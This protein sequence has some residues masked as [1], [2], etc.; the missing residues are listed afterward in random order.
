MRNPI[1]VALDGM[2]PEAAA[3]Y[4]HSLAGHVEAFKFNDLLLDANT[5]QVLRFPQKTT[6]FLDLK[7]HD[8]PNT[9]RNQVRR[10]LQHPALGVPSYT[11]DRDSPDRASQDFLTVHASGGVEMMTAAVEEARQNFRILAVTVLTSIDADG[12]QRIYGNPI[13]QVVRQLMEDAKRAGVWGVVCSAHEVSIA[14]ELGLRA[15]VPGVRP[16]WHTASDDQKRVARP[17]KAIDEGA[18]YL[19]IGRPI[20][21]PPSGIGPV[22]AVRRTLR[23]ISYSPLLEIAREASALRFGNFTLKSGRVSPYFFDAGYFHRAHHLDAVGIAYAAEIAQ[24]WP[25]VEIV[26][27]PAYKGL[28]IAVATAQALTRTLDRPISWC[29]D[30]K[31][32]KR[33]GDESQFVGVVPHEGAQVVIVDDVITTGQTKIELVGKLNLTKANVLGVVVALD[34]QEIADQNQSAVQNFQTYTGLDVAALATLD[35][36]CVQ[37]ERSSTIEPAQLDAIRSY[38]QKYGVPTGGQP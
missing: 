17:K 16:E 21:K 7:L 15:I 9:V 22:E 25:T 24:R 10:L 30:R 31:E 36:V 1:I 28:P 2:S 18:H 38:R 34:R 13:D 37:A 11:L 19:V 35:D 29:G 14:K 27:G 5:A 3:Y 8:I 12:C 20:T 33:H 23:E 4:V 32:T 26:C 6:F